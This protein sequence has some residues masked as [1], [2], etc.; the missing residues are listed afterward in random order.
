MQS[1]VSWL[2]SCLV[3]LTWVSRSSAAQLPTYDIHRDVIRGRVTTDSGRAIPGAEV[4]VTMAPDRVFQRTTS[5]SA[6]HF[7]LIWE[8]G[9]GDYLVHVVASGRMTSRKRVT[10][11]MP[12]T[13]MTV[14]FVM[15]PSVQQLATVRVQSTRTRANRETGLEMGPGIGAAEQRPTGMT[16]AVAP[17]L[18]GNL[19][20]MAATLPGVTSLPNGGVSVLGL[21]ASQNN[22]TLNG[23]AFSGTAIPR[24]AK[25]EMVV[26]TA[27]YDP[28]R[29]G[30]SGV[31]TQTTVAPGSYLS[32]R[33]AYATLDAPP[34]QTSNAVTRQ[35]GSTFA[36]VD[37]S[38]GAE[39]SLALDKWMYNTGIQ[40]RRQQ[41]DLRS[42]LTAS[43]DLL[44]HYGVSSDSAAR[45][46][47][48]LQSLGIPLSSGGAA[49]AL[50]TT[51][52]SLIAR[53]DRP[54]FNYSD[55]TPLNSTWGVL[56]FANLSRRRALSVSP[57]TL[58]SHGGETSQAD[59]AVQG[60][61]SLYFGKQRDNLTEFRTSYGIATSSSEPFVRLPDGRVLVSS[62]L[63]ANSGVAS[64]AFGGNA[65]LERELHSSTWEGTNTTHFWWRGRAAHRGKVYLQARFDEYSENSPT[66]RLGSFSY[67]SL[68]DLQANT[69]ASF[70]R[71]LDAPSRSGGE[72]SGVLAVNNAFWPHSRL[73]FQYG[74]R[75]EANAFTEKPAA[76]AQVASTFGVTNSHA[77]NTWHVSPR[78]GFTWIYTKARNTGEMSMASNLGQF[79]SAPVGALRG[80][81]GEF[82]QFLPASLIADAL[83][84]N[85]RLGGI[86]RIQC[87]GA[88]VPSPQWT[89][90]ANDPSSVPAQ[91]AGSSGLADSAPDVMLFDRGYRPARSWRGNISWSSA[92]KWISY[93]VDAI[94]T[95]GLNQP[96]VLD[97]NFAGTHAFGLS[98]EGGRPVFVPQTSIVGTTG[99]VSPVAARSSGAFAR[100]LSRLSDLRSSARQITI[101]ANPTKGNWF[102]RYYVNVAY[103]FSSAR[104]QHRGFDGA[105]AGDPRIIS[106][107]RADFAPR[108]E[109]V[110]QT[111]YGARWLTFSAY[112][113]VAS[114]TPFTPMVASDI[115]GDG[116]GNDAAY[117]FDPAAAPTVATAA[118]IQN[119]MTRGPSAVRECLRRQLRV[120]ATRNSCE[121]P[122]TAFMSASVSPTQR[123]MN[124]LKLPR[125]A[126]IT[127]NLAN[128]LGG[129]DR[130]LHGNRSR[131]W[132]TPAHP[133]PV[134][135]YVRGFDA[136]SNRFLYEVNPRFA[137]TRWGP[138]ALRVPFRAT[139]DVRMDLSRDNDAQQLDRWLKPG[140]GYPGNRLDAAALTRRF[141]GNLPRWYDQIIREADPLLLTRDQVEA[142]RGAQATYT[143]RVR[144][145]WASFAT[146]LAK[147]PDDF[148]TPDLLKRQKAHVEAGWD[149]ARQE[150]QTTLPKILT[151]VQLGLLPGNAKMIYESK[152]PIRGV[153]FFT[154]AD[155]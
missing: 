127:V 27:S 21:S 121:G 91:C 151:P 22:A 43:S 97:L 54:L 42:L 36:A 12:D 87:F 154:S 57:L 105:N 146:V 114:G 30:F 52:V 74:A 76:N 141:C 153:R 138:S 70:T 132:G 90:Y 102:S 123:L 150:A 80:G 72:W 59:A 25:T 139:I 55:F 58:P 50:Q 122:W 15:A 118:G 133:D 84:Y 3:L 125:R 103:T 128:P 115:N 95:Y 46:V 69:P 117:V 2:V 145:H 39:G 136:S 155:C 96:S 107:S 1:S 9:T 78:A 109:V 41:S 83:I 6:G 23:L 152:Q 143:A 61:Y 82:R 68:A 48:V 126:Q 26:A 75:L 108:H 47:S 92:W 62:S 44:A 93:S 31:Q 10:R 86:R 51:Q 88:E 38:A 14:D 4:A 71:A 5:D 17:D 40:V 131:G 60:L 63:G 29:G 140:R 45:L 111:A 137:D 142:L 73:A 110:L 85:G 147:Q 7:E 33:R 67:N 104:S 144:A 24:G 49:S 28:A 81:I 149:I 66:N 65:T 119:L 56:G 18:R 116:A 130:L 112:S 100:T 64:L 89:S 37:V 124:V 16:G 135:L 79:Y 77:P 101:R 94:G 13:V 32:Y 19:D 134:L 129:L 98:D 20:A 35:A 99:T 53:L 113:K 148:N 8:K 120:V 11:V 34:L 106:W